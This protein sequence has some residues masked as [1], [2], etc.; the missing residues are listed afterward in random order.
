MNPDHLIFD[1]RH[2]VISMADGGYRPPRPRDQIRVIGRTGR[3][4]LELMVLTLFLRILM[5]SN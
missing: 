1:A 4:F 2:T 3:A 5:K